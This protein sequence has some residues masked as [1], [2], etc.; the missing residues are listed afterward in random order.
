ML[1]ISSAQSWA[2]LNKEESKIRLLACL[3][4]VSSCGVTSFA[5]NC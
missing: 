2:M 5:H 4:S 3:W 1:R